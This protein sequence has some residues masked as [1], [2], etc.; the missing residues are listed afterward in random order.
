MID[1]RMGLESP[2]FPS[3]VTIALLVERQPN[4]SAVNIFPLTGEDMAVS[5]LTGH[6][7]RKAIRGNSLM[8]RRLGASCY[9]QQA[10]EKERGISP[11]PCQDDRPY[12]IRRSRVTGHGYSP[13]LS[14]VMG[15]QKHC[16]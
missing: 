9:E 8:N 4:G 14:N 10:D 12:A 1:E 7:W 13:L 2:V 15:V 5:G 3:I 6:R 11:T 16:M